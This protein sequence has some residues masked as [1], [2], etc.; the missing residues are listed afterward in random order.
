MIFFTIYFAALNNLC[1]EFVKGFNTS[2]LKVLYTTL[3]FGSIIAVFT[4][5]FDF[6]LNGFSRGVVIIFLIGLG[7]LFDSKL[8]K[9]RHQIIDNLSKSKLI[10][11]VIA[12][13]LIYTFLF[14]IFSSI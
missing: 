5:I 2:F 1:D 8:V 12:Y 6:E 9:D 10:L 4:K 13:Q 14:I 3:L 7:W 11:I